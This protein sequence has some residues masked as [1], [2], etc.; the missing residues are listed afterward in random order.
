MIYIDLTGLCDRK[1]TGIENYAFSLYEMLKKS[2]GSDQI[3]ALKV[4]NNVEQGE[5]SLGLNKGRIITEYFYLPRFLKK[6]KNDIF[7][8]PI[9]PPSIFSWRYNKNIIPVIYD[10]V[11]WNYKHTMSFKAKLLI[12][13]RMKVALKKAKKIITESITVK[14]QLLKINSKAQYHIIYNYI[15]K[16]QNASDTPI[17][18]KLGI[19]KGNYILSVSTLEPRKNFNYLLNIISKSN[20]KQKN[21]KFVLVG[22]KGWGKN[23]D[24]EINKSEAIL[25]GYLSNEDLETIYKNAFCFIMLPVDEGFGRTPIE[26]AIVKTPVIVSDIPIFHETLGEQCLYLPL[27]DEETAVNELNNII[28]NKL[29]KIPDIDAFD[30]FSYEK[31][32]EQV[33]KLNNFIYG[34]SNEIL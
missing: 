22:R 20:L 2:M 21:L 32:F 30:I 27:N 12:V 34:D 15:T 14:N 6:H 26:A 17:L 33:Q 7:I 9:F 24:Y 5:I 23:L 19:T 31:V 29:L 1:W 28:D 13:P 3:K 16:T 18:S 25:T 4:G 10:S 8:Y 11:P